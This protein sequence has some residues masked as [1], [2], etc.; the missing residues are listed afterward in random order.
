MIAFW[1][2]LIRATSALRENRPDDFQSEMSIAERAAA[3]LAQVKDLVQV[4]AL[5]ANARDGLEASGAAGTYTEL[6]A[7]LRTG[8][9]R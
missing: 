9:R 6:R 4:A 1:S 2:A 7:V 8:S 5:H 3:Q